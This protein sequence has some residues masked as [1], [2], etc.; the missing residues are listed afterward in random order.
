M[1]N[2]D[3]RFSDNVPGHWYVDEQCIGC[4][5]CGND[6]P[7]LFSPSA[8]YDHHRVYRQP[9]TVEELR[10]AEDARQSCPVEAIGNDGPV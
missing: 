7:A 8:D 3:Q 10:D 6:A 2:P 5:L 1:A 9:A 4:G